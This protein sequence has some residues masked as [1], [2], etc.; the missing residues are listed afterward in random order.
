[1]VK[2][3]DKNI[4]QNNWQHLTDELTKLDLLLQMAVLKFRESLSE[5]SQD[6][7]KGFFLSDQEIDNILIEKGSNRE[8]KCAQEKKDTQVG[9]L[10][11]SIEQLQRTISQK[12]KA[13]LQKGI[14]LVLPQLSHLFRLSPFE[15]NI[16]L[17]CFA[18]EL[19]RKYKKLYAYL[20]DDITRKQPSVDLIL[21]LLCSTREEMI[22][23]RPCF[24]P[25]AFLFKSQILKFVEDPQNPQLPLLSRILK[26][27]DRIVNF[28]MEVS[29]L[30]QRIELFSKLVYPEASPNKVPLTLELKSRLF[31]LTQNHLR[32][33][34]GDSNKLIYYFM[35]P[36]GSGK[37]SLAECIC[38]ELKVHLVIS[39]MEKLLSR[40]L[41]FEDIMRLVFREALLQPAAIYL[42]NFHRL[43]EEEKYLTHLKILASAIKEFS[44][45]TFLAGEKN[46][47]PAGLF[48]RNTF[49][50]INFPNPDYDARTELWKVLTDGNFRF[51]N[52]VDF[53]ELATKFQFTQGQIK[54]AL[55]SA[56]NLARLRQPGH[57]VITMQELYQGCRAQC[58]Q[59]LG[60]LA[61]KITPKYTW[62]DIVLP[63]DIMQQLHAICD[64]VKYRYR[65]Y[66]EW[67]FGRKLSLGK[68]LNALFS[69]PSG[70]GKTMA[71]EIIANGLELDLYKIDLSSV[72]SKYIGETE[73]NL[74]KIFYEAESSNAILFFDEADALFG[75]RSEVKDAHDRYA[76]IEIGYLLQKMEEYEGI[77]ILAT[78]LKKNMDDAFM[79]RLHFLV[80]FPFPDEN[81]RYRIWKTIFPE[82]TPV[83]KDMDFEFLSTHFKIAGGN[84]RNI[85][86]NAA[87]F[88]AGNSG[89][90]N[91]EHI[92]QATKQEYQKIGRPYVKSDFG[93]YSELVV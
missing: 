27:D 26:L 43:L 8:E 63:K 91:M 3:A 28:L 75:K 53:E 65:V 58:N 60:K 86:V 66:G 30:D 52:E 4:Y 7:F 57:S 1:M 6:T 59:K 50:K 5:K 64:Q 76:N 36:Y 51:T 41:P 15:E 81:Y 54:D 44:W 89:A 24:L 69:G 46:W 14:Y 42:K 92:L 85:A 78:N 13:S 35:G 40:E 19:D 83:S 16:I 49:L 72:V 29:T 39:D 23:A 37:Q 90:V 21:N 84:I 12:K 10:A 93:K 71:A 73:K 32:K 88:A 20:Q 31:A 34:K 82:D 79:R 74:S 47:E 77:S 18:S 22:G 62:E 38:H 67:G 80:E 9:L 55:A 2:A 70:T 87:F 48:N 68:G 33:L 17:I 45:L 11:K 25:E 56:Q 61:R